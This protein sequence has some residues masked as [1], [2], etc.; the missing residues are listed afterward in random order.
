MGKWTRRAFIGAGILTGG[1][2]IMGVA[3]R[4]GKRIGKVMGLIAEEDETVINVWLKINPD[5]VITAIL[6]HAE[7][8]QGVHTAL[9]MM[10][11]EELE[12]DWDK[13]R[14]MEAPADKEYANYVLAKGFMGEMFNIPSFLDKTVDGALLMATK[15]MGLQVTGGSASVRFTG[16]AGMRVA[17]ASAKAVL[18]QAAA[19]KWSVPLAELRAEKS[20]IY[21]DKSNQAGPYADFAKEAA[22]LSVPAKPKLKAP[23]DF[24]IIGTSPP[25][26]DIPAKVDGTAQ[27]A[28]DVK[29]PD[30][31]YATIQS[32]PVFG[33]SLKSVDQT[34]VQDMAGIHKILEIGDAVAVVADG[35]WLAKQG[36][37]KLQIDYN[38]NGNEGLNQADIYA[39]FAQALDQRDQLKTDLEVGNPLKALESGE[40][41]STHE[42]EYRVPY[43]AHS[44]MEPMNATATFKDGKCEV[45][46]GCQNPLGFRIAVADALG[47]KLE[48]VTLNNMMMGGGFGRRSET[49]IAVQAAL[50]A[51]EL[52]YPVKLIWSR[53]ED[54]RQD[55]YREATISRFKAAMDEQGMPKVWLNQFVYKMHPAEGSHIPYA[56]EHQMQQHTDVELPIPWGNWR[57]VAHSNHAFFTESFIDELAHQAGADPLEYRRSLLKENPK[58]LKVMNMAAEKANWGESMPENH[59]RGIAVHTSFGTTV[60]QIAEVSVVDGKL[61][62]HRVVCVADPGYAVHPDNFIAQI[63]GGAVYGLTAAM[64]GAINIEN[65]AVVESNFHNY[66]M[67][68]MDESPEFETYIINS[69]DAI[70]GGGEP[71]TPPIAPA[72]ANAIFAATGKRV[73]ELPFKDAD[74]N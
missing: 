73:R 4:P 23:A 55:Y 37:G 44:A 43:L 8:G 49:D 5:N 53:E 1:V 20:Y 68:R 59:G 72:V 21:H 61:K 13:L 24:K 32:P 18:L 33:A 41:A 14:F 62:V 56:V 6:P 26:I 51:K 36:L 66:Q 69:Y 31:K 28:L 50:I 67:L 45:W 47:L 27:F 29:L 35:Y 40:L 46:V 38:T 12:A 34:K 25:R 9:M 10:L 74:L 16:A 71:G 7:M 19:D 54:T 52:D 42:A 65:G 64:H 11:A 58:V 63:E 3:I 60:A 17:G 70:G 2:L 57:S 22:E 30:M 48:D 15:S 39:K